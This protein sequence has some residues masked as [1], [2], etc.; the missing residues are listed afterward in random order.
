M[1]AD[2]V[3]KTDVVD[4]MYWDHRIDASDI[5]VSVD[6]GK[7]TLTGAVPTYTAKRAAAD[8][9]WLVEGVALVEN[10]IEVEYPT[11]VSVPTDDEIAANVRD[12]FTWNTDLSA[13]EIDVSVTNGW[14]TLEGTVD[15]YWK[16]I[17]AEGEAEDVRGVIGVTN[18]LAVVPTEKITDE[19]IAE[20]VVNAIDRNRNVN[21][22]DIDVTV[23]N[24]RVTLTGTVANKTAKSAAY[25]SALYTVGVTDVEDNIILERF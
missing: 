15:A 23:S 21:V 11:T 17:E 25:N 18:K 7:V 6:D 5:A 14:V 22:D 8:N 19:S 9:A 2:E 10:D 24:G 20:D 13:F 1:R 16:K 4:Q 3:I 12:A